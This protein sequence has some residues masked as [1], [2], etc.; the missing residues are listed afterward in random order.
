MIYILGLLCLV[1]L[2]L[3]CVRWMW[4]LDREKVK[5]LS[6]NRVLSML[7]LS[8]YEY[9]LYIFTVLRLRVISI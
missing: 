6:V 2:R 4:L 5:E 1:W 3:V 7:Y 9:N 8:E